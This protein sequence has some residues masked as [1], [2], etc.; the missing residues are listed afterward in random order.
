MTDAR[1]QS[2]VKSGGRVPKA[3]EAMV[4]DRAVALWA[5]GFV[6][7]PLDRYRQQ[8]IESALPNPVRFGTDTKKLRSDIA[9]L[10]KP[11]AHGLLI[12]MWRMQLSE[13]DLAGSGLTPCGK[14][15]ATRNAL[16]KVLELDSGEP[17]AESLEQSEREKRAAK[18]VRSAS[19]IVEAAITFGLIEEL[20]AQTGPVKCKPLRGTDKLD[21]FMTA[22]GVDYAVRLRE[23]FLDGGQELC[24]AAGQP[25]S[26]KGGSK[27]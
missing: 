3:E 17:P 6:L 1:A 2:P 11:S 13:K 20:P 16:G 26:R 24:D 21:K 7:Y 14:K 9:R 19:R 4:T 15:P 27:K 12:L 10:S 25:R 8:L 18:Y 22:L 5:F 23:A